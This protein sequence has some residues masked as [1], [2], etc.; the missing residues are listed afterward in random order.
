MGKKMIVSIIALSMALVMSFPQVSQAASVTDLCVRC[1]STVPDVNTGLEGQLY[2]SVFPDISY[3]GY[4]ENLLDCL[5]TFDFSLF[6]NYD[7]YY[8]A[9][10]RSGSYM[11]LQ[12]CVF[13]SDITPLIVT[14]NYYSSTTSNFG[15]A[16]ATGSYKL[17]TNYVLTSG[18]GSWSNASGGTFNEV[19]IYQYDTDYGTGQSFQYILDTNVSVYGSSE[20][21]PKSG[22]EGNWATNTVKNWFFNENGYE[23]CTN[24]FADTEG[25]DLEGN[26]VSGDGTGAFGDT[27]YQGQIA[28]AEKYLKTVYTNNQGANESALFKWSL[29]GRSASVIEEGGITKWNM[30]YIIIVKWHW[31]QATNSTIYSPLLSGGSGG[32]VMFE[33]DQKPE[34]IMQDQVRFSIWDL[35]QNYKSVTP[36]SQSELVSLAVAVCALNGDQ[37]RSV[38]SDLFG[39]T[40]QYLSDIAGDILSGNNLSIQGVNISSSVVNDIFNPSYYYALDNLEMQLKAYPWCENAS[41]KKRGGAADMF[42]N[43]RTNDSAGTSEGYVDDGGTPD[44]PSDDTQEPSNQNPSD[45]TV[46]VPQVYPTG[47]GDVDVYVQIQNPI[48][49]S[50]GTGANNLTFNPSYSPSYNPTLVVDSGIGEFQETIQSYPDVTNK[51]FWDYFIVFKDNDFLESTD[52]FFEVMPTPIKDAIIASITIISIFAIYRFVRRG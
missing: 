50:G 13:N 22:L 36:I 37:T 11:N 27:S 46:V 6:E 28:F 29:D 34:H 38:F 49:P 14:D 39:Q 5:A 10:Y 21:G 45:D 20:I 48:V 33:F 24:I 43:L 19:Y 2:G 51:N 35:V 40:G 9:A 41:F 31:T 52:E 42:L 18:F 3:Q 26:L 12:I 30:H 16:Y 7:Y 44:D 23:L 8:I 47:V 25:Y 17:Y 15:Y 1:Q 4:N 32:S